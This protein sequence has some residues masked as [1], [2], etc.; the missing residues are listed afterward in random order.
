VFF[1]F[2]NFLISCSPGVLLRYIL[3][4][5][6][7]VLSALTITVITFKFTFHKLCISIQRSL[8]FRTSLASILITFLSHEIA[9]HINLYLPFSLSRILMSGLL[10]GI[11]LS[12]RTRWFH[13]M[14]TGQLKCGGTRAENRFRLSA[15]RKSPFKSAGGGGG[16]V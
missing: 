8:Y 12:V 6:E 15:K 13:N 1:I 14:I 3:N 7:M 10:S 4:D 11:V 2:C 16:A 5:F 9:T